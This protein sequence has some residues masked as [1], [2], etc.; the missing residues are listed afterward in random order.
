MSAASGDTHR[1][2]FS[3]QVGEAFDYRWSSIKNPN[4]LEKQTPEGFH[5]VG[6]RIGGAATLNQRQRNRTGFEE[7]EIFGGPCGGNDLESNAVAREQTRVFLREGIVGSILCSRCN[8]YG[9]G[10]R[11]LDKLIGG[12]KP[13]NNDQSE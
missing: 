7:V 5:L 11:R 3:F 10:W 2:A 13:Q 1:H 8:P 12:Q 6:V 4:R 9:L